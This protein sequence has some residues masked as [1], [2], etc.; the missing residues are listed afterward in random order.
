M[1]TYPTKAVY[2]ITATIGAARAAAP[3]GTSAQRR[4]LRLGMYWTALASMLRSK[5]TRK[6]SSG[7]ARLFAASLCAA[8][9]FCGNAFAQDWSQSGGNTTAGSNAA[10]DMVAHRLNDSL[11]R[12]MF[13]NFNLFIYVDKAERG[14]FALRMFVFEKTG[15]NFAP[16]Y[17]WP[18]STG[19]ESLERDAH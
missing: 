8:V 12:E 11:S 7:R 19:R 2:G 3:E 1:V 9:F 5:V 13:A 15:D 17:D 18:V 4:A 14:P 10:V 16:L 6:Q